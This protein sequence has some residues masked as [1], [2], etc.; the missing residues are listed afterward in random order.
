MMVCE[1]QTY[2]QDPLSL[3]AVAEQCARTDPGE[4]IDIRARDESFKAAIADE[5][6]ANKL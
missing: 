2:F 3:A 6:E 4:E 1:W 5:L